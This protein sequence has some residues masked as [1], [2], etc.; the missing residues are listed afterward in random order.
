MAFLRICTEIQ[1]WQGAG[2]TTSMGFIL[3]N[4]AFVVDEVEIEIEFRSSESKIL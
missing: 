2:L 1:K 3:K 4:T